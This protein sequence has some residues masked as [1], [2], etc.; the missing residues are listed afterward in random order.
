M[1]T[2]KTVPVGVK[3]ISVLFYIGAVLSVLFGLLSFVGASLFGALFSNIPALSFIGA[4]SFVVLGVVML[5]LG[6][7]DFFVGRGLWKGHNW[8]RIV[9]VILAA[10]GVLMQLLALLGGRISA[11]VFLVIYLVIGG[12]LLL[13]NDVKAS[14]S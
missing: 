4:G 6:V 3:V 10:L 1:A 14:F 13:N 12:Y 9:A 2:M 8:A 11:I 5:A 7:L